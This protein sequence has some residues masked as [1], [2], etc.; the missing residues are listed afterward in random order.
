MGPEY[1]TG[2]VNGCILKFL[3]DDFPVWFLH[4]LDYL[5]MQYTDKVFSQRTENIFKPF[6]SVDTA[7]SGSYKNLLKIYEN[8]KNR[9][10]KKVFIP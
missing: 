8:L 5:I 7:S 10:L 2:Q 6:T 9:Y 1:K 4:R 3:W